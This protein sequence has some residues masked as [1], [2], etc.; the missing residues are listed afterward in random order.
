MKKPSM[1][2]A[3]VAVLAAPPAAAVSLGPLTKS[4][5][6]DGPDKAFYLSLGNPYQGE[7]RFVASAI[8]ADDENAQGRVTIFPSDVRLGPQMR[9]QILIIIRNLEPGEHYSFRVC[10]ERAP[11]PSETVRARVCSKLNARRLL[12]RG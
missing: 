1:I 8:G 12:V 4:G 3:G 9:R 6:T 5:I 2:C 10:A 11:L 7:E